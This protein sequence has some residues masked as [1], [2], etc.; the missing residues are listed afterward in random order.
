LNLDV[1]SHDS[2]VVVGTLNDI[3]VSPENLE[4]LTSTGIEYTV[5]IDDLEALITEERL[6][7]ANLKNDNNTLKDDEWYKSYHN[8]NDIVAYLVGLSQTYPDLT[9]YY[10]SIGLTIEKRNIP[11]I[12][13]SSGSPSTKKRVFIN[14]GQHAREWV[15]PTTVMYIAEQLLSSTEDEVKKILESI[16]FVIVPVVN[17]DGYSYTWTNNRLWRKN[18]RP[19]A[20]GSFGVDLN[21]NWADHWGGDGS[22]GIPS[23]DTYRG[24]AP[25][26]EPETTATKNFLLQFAPIKGAIDFHSYS[27]L[28][29][30]PYGWTSRPPPNEAE[31]KLVGDTMRARILAV[32]GKAYSSIPSYNLYVTSGSAQDWY[33]GQAAVPLSFT[34]ELRDTGQYGFQLP[35]NQILPTAQE[36]WAAVKYFAN[37]IIAN[38]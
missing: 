27:Q 6:F 9:Q 1:W 30:R 2:V 4:L 5:M 37:Y 22:S 31:G 7:H 18:R 21:R 3:A 15:S 33:Y 11:A 20:G 23:S 36:N 24:T 8:F 12:V 10:P 26:S 38:S 29:L 16:A 13:I 17:P 25:F 19:N 14:G 28:I 35:A 34:I 32:F